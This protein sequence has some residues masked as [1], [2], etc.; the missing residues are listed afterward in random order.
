MHSLIR[1][2]ISKPDRKSGGKIAPLPAAEV[3]YQ[4]QYTPGS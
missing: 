2:A 1:Q 4:Y 3:E